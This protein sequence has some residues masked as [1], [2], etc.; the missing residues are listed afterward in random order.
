MDKRGTAS[1]IESAVNSENNATG[2]RAPWERPAVQML[3]A[4][5]AEA[6]NTGNTDATDNFS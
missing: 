1:E 4:Y 2:E 5:L 3:H 6:Q